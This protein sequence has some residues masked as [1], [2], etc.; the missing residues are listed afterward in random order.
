[1]AEKFN[2]RFVAALHRRFR[3]EFLM[4]RYRR[5]GERVAVVVY[6]TNLD[7]RPAHIDTNKIRRNRVFQR[8]SFTR[9]DIDVV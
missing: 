1:M 9:H 8:I 4:G 7:V 5:P 6:D 3:A 2:D